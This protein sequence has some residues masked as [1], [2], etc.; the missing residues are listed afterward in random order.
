M[1]LPSRPPPELHELAVF[2]EQ[3]RVLEMIRSVTVIRKK[4]KD[5]Q[6]LRVGVSLE[7]MN[8]L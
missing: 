7:K 6:F 5:D 3:R 2:F 8:H 1:K 4:E